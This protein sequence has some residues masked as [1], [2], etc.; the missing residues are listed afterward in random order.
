MGWML[1]PPGWCPEK[2]RMAGGGGS[3]KESLGTYIRVIKGFVS[4][5]YG[6]SFVWISEMTVGLANQN[7]QH[8]LSGGSC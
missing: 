2:L 1:Q 8:A 7:I 6:F 5:W 4:Y 3:W